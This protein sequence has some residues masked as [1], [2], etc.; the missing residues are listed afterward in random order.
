[1]ISV[2]GTHAQRAI[3]GAR[4]CGAAGTAP[5][6]ARAHANQPQVPLETTAA[7]LSWAIFGTALDWSR[8]PERSPAAA[9]AAQIATLLTGGLSSVLPDSE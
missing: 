6:P 8:M 2:G 5:A 4:P 9:T 1:M 7:G 3:V